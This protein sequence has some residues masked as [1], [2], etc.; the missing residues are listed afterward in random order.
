MQKK[1]IIPPASTDLPKTPFP[2][3]VQLRRKLDPARVPRMSA[4]MRA[5]VAY[6]IGVERWANPP[7][8]ELTVTSDLFVLARVGD[9]I[10]FDTFGGSCTDLGR[11]WLSLLSAAGLTTDESWEADC[12][13]AARVGF[14]GRATA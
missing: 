7:I 9:Q 8:R 5:I 4:M 14:Y 10:G 12:R 1:P 11:N 2:V 3:E 13:F 6:I